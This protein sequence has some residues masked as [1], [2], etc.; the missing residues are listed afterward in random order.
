M[1]H[2]N[3][4]PETLDELIIDSLPTDWKEKV[5]SGRALLEDVPM[6]IRFKA[7][8]DGVTGYWISGLSPDDFR[9]IHRQ[10]HM[11]PGNVKLWRPPEGGKRD[12]SYWSNH[13][14]LLDEITVT[15]LPEEWRIVVEA[16]DILPEDVPEE[17]RD[18]AMNEG[19]T[20]YWADRFDLARDQ[21]KEARLYGTTHT[22]ER[23]I[24]KEEESAEAVGK[25]MEKGKARLGKTIGKI[26]DRCEEKRDAEEPEKQEEDEGIFG[27][28]E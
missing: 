26:L 9:K 18:K 20:E 13:P 11:L 15:H 22:P 5:E 8:N 4:R 10:E 24:S 2:R 28:V 23:T 17:I 1:S 3:R 12:M 6:G 19:I 25:K 16:G 14:E 7:M 27:E 21:A